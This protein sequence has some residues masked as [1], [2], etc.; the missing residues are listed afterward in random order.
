MA[1]AS[2]GVQRILGGFASRCARRACPGGRSAG[3]VG[4]RRRPRRPGETGPG[5]RS[6][7]VRATEVLALRDVLR[8]GQAVLSPRRGGPP[9][10]AVLPLFAVLIV[11]MPAS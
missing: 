6:P 2:S 11:L 8:A 3:L 5:P 4:R 1:V 9:P 7:P 10:A